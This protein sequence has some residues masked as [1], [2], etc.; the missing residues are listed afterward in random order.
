MQEIKVN[1]F[2]LISSHAAVATDDGNK[3][4]DR[5]NKIFKSKNKV[6]LDFN[7]IE[8]ITST[9]LNSSIGRLYGHYDS[10]FIKEHLSINNLNDDDL[11][12]LKK[13][14]ERAKE[15]FTQKEKMEK[16]IRETLEN[17]E[18]N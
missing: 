6:V 14:V 11:L 8:L 1:I 9:F 3:L 5:I 13:V 7:N 17:E 2:E 10:N 16:G 15:Y 4:Y 12:L 18:D